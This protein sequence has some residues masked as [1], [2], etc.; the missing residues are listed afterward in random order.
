MNNGCQYS[1]S[2]FRAMDTSELRRKIHEQSV[3]SVYT[4]TK[5]KKSKKRPALRKKPQ[6]RESIEQQHFFGWLAWQYPEVHALAFHVPNG[7]QR[8]VRVAAKLKKEGV[9]K[10]VPDIFIMLPRGAYHGCIIEL[11]ATSTTGKS[12]PK[13]TGE[14]QEWL[15]RLT[16]QGYYA[17]LCVGREEA[18]AVMRAYVSLPQA[19]VITE[20]VNLLREGLEEYHSQYGEDAIA[21]KYNMGA[22]LQLTSPWGH[23]NELA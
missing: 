8:D 16:A 2:G 3:S 11:K 19:Q 20:H 12:R 23:L 21:K 4:T 14:Q 18:Q 1:G 10:G 17:K 6:Q 15:D 13:P 22:A 7:G 9:K 5:A